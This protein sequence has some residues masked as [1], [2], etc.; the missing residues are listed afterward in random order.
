M[1]SRKTGP[2]K[3][4]T[5]GPRFLL[6]HGWAYASSAVAVFVPTILATWPGA[7]PHADCGKAAVY[8]SFDKW[9]LLAD[10]VVAQV[11]ELARA[12][13][14]VIFIS[15]SPKLMPQDV[16]RLLPYVREVV[17]RR[18]VG[19]DFGAYKDGIARLGPL[20]GLDSLVLMNDSCYGPFG[21]LARVEAAAA[22]SGADLFGITE[23]WS[24]RYHLQ[25]YYVRIGARAL[26]APAFAAF[27]R[28]LLPSQPRSMVITNGEIRFT[29]ILLKAGMTAS[30]LC[31]YADAARRAASAAQNLLLANDA[32]MPAWQASYLKHL[33][34]C[35]LDGTPLN[36]THSFWD[37]LLTECGAP[38][39]KRELLRHNPVRIPGVSLWE[40]V[41][42]NLPQLDLPRAELDLIRNHLKLG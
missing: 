16:A 20:A 10:Y 42:A 32:A 36:P 38:F 12:G 4:F 1:F 34:N 17:H 28:S 22:A 33:L 8:V 35:I 30:V 37:V 31:P 24:I 39:V 9:G 14:R 29:Q 6:R 18:N 21:G 19:H 2:S 23:S 7:D 41:L 15:T 26:N 40:H 5:A 25:T 27:W 11:A 13:R 3:P